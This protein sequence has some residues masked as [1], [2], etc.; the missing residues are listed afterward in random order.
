MKRIEWTEEQR[1]KFAAK[2]PC[3]DIPATGY[4]VVDSD[5]HLADLSDNT[6][7]CEC[8]G[9]LIPFLSDLANEYNARQ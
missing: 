4:V 6:R 1:D 7:D 8:N 2:W 5:G 3:C 9:G